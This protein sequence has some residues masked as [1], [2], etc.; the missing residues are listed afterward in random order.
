MKKYRFI[1]KSQFKIRSLNRSLQYIVI[2]THDIFYYKENFGWRLVN[3]RILSENSWD[4]LVKFIMKHGPIS[5]DSKFDLE[6]LLPKT[7]PN[8]KFF[9]MSIT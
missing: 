2:D 4:V 8:V 5:P 6:M 7:D 1:E 9:L 3:S